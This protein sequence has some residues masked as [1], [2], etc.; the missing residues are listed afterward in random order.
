LTWIGL[1]NSAW[2]GSPADVENVL[3]ARVTFEVDEV[4]DSFG[5]DGG[6]GLN[7][8]VGRT[9]CSDRGSIG[10]CKLK[11]EQCGEGDSLHIKTLQ[12]KRKGTEDKDLSSNRD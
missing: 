3:G 11:D 7:A 2:P 5:V 9:K 4:K 1:E 10:C 12:E 8:V 6:L